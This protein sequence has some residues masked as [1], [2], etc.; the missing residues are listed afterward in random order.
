MNE[1]H[2]TFSDLL[3]SIK[4]IEKIASAQ[5]FDHYDDFIMKLQNLHQDLSQL[6]LSENSSTE[7]FQSKVMSQGPVFAHVRESRNSL[8][9]DVS[10][11]LKIAYDEYWEYKDNLKNHFFES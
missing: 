3:N 4:K 9:N 8:G 10:D 6:G 5:G 11:E 7:E 1:M 2:Q